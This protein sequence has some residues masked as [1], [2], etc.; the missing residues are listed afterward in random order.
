MKKLVISTLFVMQVFF[1]FAQTTTGITGKVVD[2]KTQKPL[3]NVVA[4]IL[5]TNFTQLTDGTGKFTFSDVPQ[6]NQL[7]QIKTQGY[8]DQ[9]LQV[10]IVKGQVLDMGVVVADEDITQ[11]QQLS[12]ITITENDLGDDNSGSESTSG[13][14][15]ASRDEFQQSAAF[16]WGQARFRMRGLD[17]EYGT[18]MI[19]GITMNKI[20]DGRPQFS[21]WGGLNDATRNQEFTNGSAPSDYTFGG[22]LGTQE[23]NTRASIYRKGSRISV[24]GTNTNYT[25]RIMATSAT[26]M[27]NDGWAYTIS[28]SR[29][30]AQN[31]YF[32]GTTY[33]ANSLFAS[34]ERKIS[35][36]NSLN[37]TAIYGQNRRGKNSPNTKEVT[38]L[39]G[40]KYNSYWGWQGGDK[41]NSRVKT[42]EEPL[43]ILSDYWK[44]SKKTNLNLNFAYQF[45]QI[46]NSR[47]DYQ[48]AN[49]P[50]PTYYRNMPSFFTSQYE[51]DPATVMLNSPS[52]YLPGGLGGIWEGDTGSSTAPFL[53]NKQIDWNNLYAVNA[54]SKAIG[55]GSKYI[56]Y[57][58][59]TDDRQWTANGVLS[60]QLAD[61][62]VLNAGGNFTK[63]KSHNFKNLLDLLGGTYFRD[64][65]LYGTGDQQQIDLNNPDRKVVEG[66]T[67]G[68]NYNLFTTSYNGFT[69][70]K[71]SYKKVD[72]YVGQTFSHVEYQ[73]EGLYKNGYYPTNSYGYGDKV[74]YNTFGFKGGLTY[75]IT[76]RQ[77]FTVNGAFMTKAPSL[78]NVFSN[79]RVNNNITTGITPETVSSVDA[80]YIINAPKLK[81]RITAYFQK[82][83]IKQKHPSSSQT[84]LLLIME[85]LEEVQPT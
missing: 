19:N 68:Y 22:I 5:N 40:E 46:G 50:D 74:Q 69:Q 63:L 81:T 75:K 53:T 29:R 61:N 72:F 27:R 18:T 1:A 45:G 20:Y 26:G 65:T 25:G 84:V 42:V 49:N 77:F 54:A 62:I 52:A 4:T 7:L 82:L 38:N 67:F 41:R 11:E 73:R 24:A 58:D 31:G 8:K 64:V 28:A 6:G 3:Q 15:Q 13:L 57:E 79:A 70:F 85:K 48:G 47:L 10:V 39:E 78:R 36:K 17:S 83:K 16:N 59:R 56:S 30:F 71:F 80:S 12:L 33:N 32:D 2:S 44:I 21:N 76:G 55:E 37:F 35:D 51:N 66:D 60:S 23:I 43:F 14:L 9:L 34:V